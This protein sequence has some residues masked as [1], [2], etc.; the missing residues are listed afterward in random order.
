MRS[1]WGTAG[2]ESTPGRIAERNGCTALWP[3]RISTA[4][5]RER[6]DAAR[7]T[8]VRSAVCGDTAHSLI[9]CT[10]PRRPARARP[11]T[12]DRAPSLDESPAR[13]QLI[14]CTNVKISLA[15]LSPARARP[16]ISRSG[17]SAQSAPL[18]RRGRR[19]RWGRT[20]RRRRARRREHVSA[21]LPLRKR[22]EGTRALPASPAR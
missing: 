9:R 19:G 18:S 2:R 21:G 10:L 6:R 12:P 11:P 14:P 22:R 3:G 13:P 5:R 8:T 20:I 7:R 16:L 17:P 15:R 1:G 4:D